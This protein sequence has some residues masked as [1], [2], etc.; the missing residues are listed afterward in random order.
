[1]I[2]HLNK[3][4]LPSSIYNKLQHKKFGPYILDLPPDVKISSTFNITDIHLYYPPDDVTVHIENS[5]SSSFT[6]SG[7]DAGA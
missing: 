5:E 4:R 2:V 6:D 1:M 3:H 7:S